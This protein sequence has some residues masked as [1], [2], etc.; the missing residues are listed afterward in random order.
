M[1]EKALN[2]IQ[3]I[4]YNSLGIITIL[5]PIAAAAIMLLLLSHK[6]TKE[7]IL[8]ISK[9]ASLT[10]LIAAIATVFFG[11]LIFKLFGINLLSI[12]LIGGIV[13]LTIYL[14]MIQGQIGTGETHS[15]EEAHEAKQKDDISIIPLGIPI[16]FGPGVIATLIVLKTKSS[17]IFEQLM[18]YAAILISVV[19][20]YL[21]LRN[22]HFISKFL[23]IT[24][25]KIATRIMGLI[26]GAIASQF[27]VS[28]AK[29][30][31]NL[32]GN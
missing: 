4:L 5:N 19:V 3:L 22:A 16:L 2:L 7:E 20:V 6:T 11:D 13:L 32:K 15:E 31:W 26:V 17:T 29:G 8:N 24:G 25:L 27:I 21:T 1:E 9:M 28:G 14:N 30:L 23:K 18:L 10:I 12:K